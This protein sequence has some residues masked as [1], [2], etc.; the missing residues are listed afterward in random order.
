[1]LTLIIQTNH[2]RT[3]FLTKLFKER[4]DRVIQAK[5]AA[6]FFK[7]ID[8]FNP[9]LVLID[10]ELPDKFIAKTT[11]FINQKSPQTHI[12]VT[13]QR[14]DLDREIGIK[15]LGPRVFL[16]APFTL[17]RLD[18]AIAQTT[19]LTAQTSL[20]SK[21]LR[22]TLPKIKTPVQLKIILPYL[23]L[24]ILLAIG[25]GYIVTQVA[26]DAIEDRFTNNLIE[27][28]KLATTWMVEEEKRKL[29]SLRLIAHLENLP[30]A[31]G[32]GTAEQIRELIYG[33]VL[34]SKE[35]AVEI[36]NTDGIALFSMRH[37]SGGLTEEYDFSQL[38]SIFA[39]QDFLEK[40]FSGEVDSEGDKYVEIVELPLEKYLYFA[41][42]ITN[43]EDRVIGAVMVGRTL[44]TLAFDMRKS[45]LGEENT[46]TQI[47][48][49]DQTGKV[50]ATTLIGAGDLTISS[51]MVS[52]TI[53]AQST[54]SQIRSLTA[55]GIDYREII[56]A[57]EVR[58]G[59]DIG[60]LGVSLAESFFVRPSLLT[61]IQIIL[62]A[63]ITTLMIIV[64]G[65]YIS[66]LITMPLAQVV[67]AAARVS[68]GK[69]DVHVEPKSQDELGY[70]AHTFNS[71]TSHLREGEI[72][73]DLLGRTITPQIRD[74]LRKGIS[75]GNLK[76]GGKN[77]T[78]T[79]MI[80]DIR[81]Y[82]SMADEY[83][84]STILSWLDSYF[85][86][87]VSIIN[88]HGGLTHTF[89]GDSL[90]AVFGELPENL[91]AQESAL[92]A[93]RAAI[94][95]LDNIKSMNAHRKERGEPPLVTGIG[96]NTGKV[97]AGGMGSFD[98]L[99]YAIIG[100]TVNV[101]DRVENLT[102]IM[103][104]TCALITDDTYVALGKYR[105]EF[106]LISQG[107]HSLKGKQEPVKIYRLLK[108]G[109]KA[110]AKRTIRGPFILDGDAQ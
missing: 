35:E 22:A 8:S 42:P 87:L 57:W 73:R 62:F 1:M 52:S 71:M 46:F 68:Q 21:K 96:I 24:A 31:I 92:Q 80:T 19:N 7:S 104:V 88:S 47:T 79:I 65:V 101:T 86:E 90:K 10:A 9:D 69:W 29:E 75:T 55:S 81:G 27:S 23:I 103:G 93:C 102:K 33:V 89:A 4:G 44:N 83:D 56:G 107:N 28:G 25:G 61:Q 82:T 74:Q 51:D 16:R 15:K 67:T 50:L 66:R 14:F 106:Q 84:P 41:G 110:D 98:R 85:G 20:A 49:Y 36:L 91:P 34:N 32:N 97:A 59:T 72:Y 78:A 100:D 26:L 95:I 70:L 2:G 12:L 3:N 43:S 54:G 53:K 94:D 13:S 105:K 76:L 64:I 39:N 5:S 77:S 48:F 58:N 99:H 11:R 17:S 6:E 108:P 45:L 30:E 109:A 37:V 40:I 63:T 60:L 38:D 18:R